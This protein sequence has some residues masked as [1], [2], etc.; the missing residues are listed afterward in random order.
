[1]NTTAP[2]R[3]ELTGYLPCPECGSNDSWNDL[4]C[5]ECGL[6]FFPPSEAYWAESTMPVSERIERLIAGPEPRDNG[7]IL[8]QNLGEEEW[9]GG[10]RLL[11]CPHCGLTSFGEL[12]P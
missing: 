9:R 6:E 2:G 12:T 3:N 1:L 10:F 8:V 11:G 5:M 4:G 7:P